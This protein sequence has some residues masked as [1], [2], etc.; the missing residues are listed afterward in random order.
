MTEFRIK[1]SRDESI[2]KT[3]RMKSS[4]IEEITALAHNHGIS[5]NAL[6]VQ[7]CEFALLHLPGREKGGGEEF[8]L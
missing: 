4:L 3:I 8:R 1:G 2:N 7:M 5:F 6:V